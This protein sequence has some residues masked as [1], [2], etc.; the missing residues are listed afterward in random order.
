[1]IDVSL[2]GVSS[3]LTSTLAPTVSAALTGP[4]AVPELPYSNR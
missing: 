2:C 4:V 3:L 1:V